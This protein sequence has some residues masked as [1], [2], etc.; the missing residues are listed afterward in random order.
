MMIDQK[1]MGNMNMHRKRGALPH[2]WKSCGNMGIYS[3]RMCALW[4]KMC[5]LGAKNVRTLIENVRALQK[6]KSVRWKKFSA[7]DQM[8]TRSIY[9]EAGTGGNCTQFRNSLPSVCSF[10]SQRVERCEFRKLK[11]RY[12]MY[13][14]LQTFL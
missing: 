12:R 11:N 4:P 8:L 7:Y 3:H 10:T 1:A 13:H 2:T 5:A 6:A 9:S 14:I